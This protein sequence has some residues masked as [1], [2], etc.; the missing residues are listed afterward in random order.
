MPLKRFYQYN[1]QKKVEFAED[2][3]VLRNHCE[4][5]F[6]SYHSFTSDLKQPKVE[7]TGLPD[8]PIYTL[9][10][11]VPQSWLVRPQESVH[12]L[13]NIQLAGEERIQAGFSLDYL[14]IEGHARDRVNAAP[15]GLQLQLTSEG[16]PVADTLVV[17]NLGYF[18][19]KSKPGVYELEIRPGRGREIFEMT[20]A[21]N[22]GW[23]SPS[24]DEAGV[25]ITITSFEGITLYP[26]FKRKEGMDNE[27]VLAS[28]DEGS[29]IFGNIADR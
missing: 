12:D 6:D 17:A 14:V 20:S 23:E 13:D 7:F 3:S 16:A 28:G 1:L 19:L 25:A 2:Q 24:V 22:Q 5:P 11:D 18:Q 9:A 10:M 8:E 21:G 26:T 27:D 4:A 29:G 15:R